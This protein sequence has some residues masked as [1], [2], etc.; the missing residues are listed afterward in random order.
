MT[1]HTDL[2]RLAEAIAAGADLTSEERAAAAQ[3]LRAISRPRN[4]TRDEI[5][6]DGM[7]RFCGHLPSARAQAE[8]FGAGWRR[9][10][11]GAWLHERLLDQ[12]PARRVG[13]IEYVYWQALKIY[14]HV[15]GA[16]RLR[17]LVG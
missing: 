8:A 10:E 13:K 1:V 9:Y 15:L 4:A 7:A 6:A 11:A 16:E 5:L 12:P 2:H 14:P 17:R 3:A